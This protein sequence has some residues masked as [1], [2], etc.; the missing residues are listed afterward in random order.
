[1]ISRALAS[2]ERH[3]GGPDAAVVQRAVIRREIEEG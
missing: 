2:L 1:V 3:A